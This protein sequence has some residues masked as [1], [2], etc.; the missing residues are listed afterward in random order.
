MVIGQGRFLNPSACATQA[1]DQLRQWDLQRTDQ[2]SQTCPQQKGSDQQPLG[3]L[4]ISTPF[5][6]G[7]HRGCPHSEETE[8]PEQKTEYHACQRKRAQQVRLPQLANDRGVN[9][10][11]YRCSEISENDGSCQFTH[12]ADMDES[13]GHLLTDSA[14]G[15]ASS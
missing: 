5:G 12:L 13:G 4:A 3:F 1:E 14:E 15:V 6:L 7:N 8:D 2:Y 11:Q 9:K 10:S